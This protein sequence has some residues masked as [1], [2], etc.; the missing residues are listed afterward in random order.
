MNYTTREENKLKNLKKNVVI[1]GKKSI[2][3]KPEP[4]GAGPLPSDVWGHTHSFK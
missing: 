1:V 2:N 3:R 4:K